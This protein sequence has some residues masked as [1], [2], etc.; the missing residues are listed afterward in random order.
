[1]YELFVLD[2]NIW[3]YVNVCKKTL[4]KQQHEK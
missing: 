1:M 2:W 4:K 3:C